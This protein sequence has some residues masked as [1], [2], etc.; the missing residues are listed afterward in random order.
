MRV[1]SRFAR[2][3]KTPYLQ[4]LLAQYC[5]EIDEPIDIVYTWV[6]GTDPDFQDTIHQFK[7]ENG[8]IGEGELVSRRFHGTKLVSKLNPKYIFRYGSIEVFAK[9]D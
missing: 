1:F 4:A 5:P 7:L 3:L 6:N 2:Q 8:E 9:V